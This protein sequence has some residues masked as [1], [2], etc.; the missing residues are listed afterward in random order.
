MDDTTGIGY[1]GGAIPPIGNFQQIPTDQLHAIQKELSQKHNVLETLNQ[2]YQL[3]IEKNNKHLE[4]VKKVYEEQ[5]KMMRENHHN[6]I[7]YER[8]GREMLMK[9]MNVSLF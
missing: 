8:K 2:R 4:D 6:D 1:L 5:I 7:E 9:E 3:E